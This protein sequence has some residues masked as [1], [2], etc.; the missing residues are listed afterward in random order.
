MPYITLVELYYQDLKMLEC[1]MRWGAA[2]KKL[3][4]RRRLRNVM[5]GQNAQKIEKGLLYIKWQNYIIQWVLNL[6]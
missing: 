4:N 2:T 6:S 1:G 5:R 3:E